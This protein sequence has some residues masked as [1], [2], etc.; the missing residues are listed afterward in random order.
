MTNT[1]K[2]FW[3][4]KSA[5]FKNGSRGQ[6]TLPGLQGDVGSALPSANIQN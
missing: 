1:N 3:K 5:L 4:E 2:Y 6:R